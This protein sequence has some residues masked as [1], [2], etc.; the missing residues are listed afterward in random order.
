MLN[1]NQQKILEKEKQTWTPSAKTERTSADLTHDLKPRRLS[2]MQSWKLAPP[3]LLLLPFSS[4]FFL[5]WVTARFNDCYHK[6]THKPSP[7]ALSSS[8]PSCLLTDWG[9]LGSTQK[10]GCSS[11]NWGSRT[12]QSPYQLLFSSNEWHY[13]NPSP[14]CVSVWR[15]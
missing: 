9:P 2:Q 7:Q 6:N 14:S 5:L 15:Q 13:W 11:V 12:E 1:G 3:Q 4:S 8:T 10:H